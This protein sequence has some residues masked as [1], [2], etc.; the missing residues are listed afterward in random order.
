MEELTKEERK[1]LYDLVVNV[2][3]QISL[4]SLPQSKK[5]KMMMAL[6][7]KLELKSDA[8]D[9]TIIEEEGNADAGLSGRG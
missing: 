1:F 6:A 3:I 5:I 7:A 4:A 8:G 9:A 2:P